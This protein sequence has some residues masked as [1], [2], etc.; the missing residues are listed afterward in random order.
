MASGQRNAAEPAVVYLRILEPDIGRMTETADSAHG[1]VMSV[2]MT[3]KAVRPGAET[4]SPHMTLRA[5][6]S[7]VIPCQCVSCFDVM[8][9][10]RL[11]D[12]RNQPLTSLV[13]LMALV[14]GFVPALRVAVEF[15]SGIA[16]GADS[17]MAGETLVHGTRSTEIVAHV[18]MGGI[19]LMLRTERSGRDRGKEVESRQGRRCAQDRQQGASEEF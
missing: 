13:F 2:L 8:M 19:G 11:I 14:A 6:E 1:T 7:R 16:I 4:E 17:R 5:I 18:A 9:E 12:G 15:P 10:T 3:P